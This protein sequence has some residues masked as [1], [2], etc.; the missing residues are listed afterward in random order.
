MKRVLLA[1]DDFAVL[2]IT[3][4]VLEHEGFSVE[5]ATNGEDALAMA[6]SE[7]PDIVVTDFMMPLMNG[8]ELARRMRASPSLATIP[9]IMVSATS[10][11]EVGSM[12]DLGVIFVPKPVT[13]DALLEAMRRVLPG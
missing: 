3:K 4:L 12:H 7:P 13:L 1:D 2:E 10:A 5:T 6:Q 11:D 8:A 9:I